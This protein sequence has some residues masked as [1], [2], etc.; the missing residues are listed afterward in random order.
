ME[1]EQL[2]EAAADTYPLDEAAIEILAEINQQQAALNA[3]MNGALSLFAKQHKLQ[4]QWRLASNG[5][6]LVKAT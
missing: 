2:I 1:Q 6:E 4:G 3:S 5:K